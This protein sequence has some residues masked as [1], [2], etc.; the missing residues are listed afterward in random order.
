MPENH[1]NSTARGYDRRWRKLRKRKLQSDPLC[2]DCLER[3]RTTLAQE[4]DHIIRITK[5]PDLRLVWDNL[6]SLCKPCHDAK[7]AAER[8]GRPVKG[9]DVHGVP[10]DPGHH[11]R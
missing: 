9:C 11:W 3:G 8:S 4:V 5:R 7:S 6:R 1:N 2:E 10:L